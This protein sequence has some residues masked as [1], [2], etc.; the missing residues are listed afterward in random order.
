MLTEC[1]KDIPEL[2]G[3]YH[4]R[5]KEEILY[6]GKAKNLK[7][8]IR[9]YFTAKNTKKEEL[10]LEQSSSVD[11]TVTE[12]EIE[13]LILEEN[14]IKENQPRYNISLKDDKRYP[15]IKVTL[16]D[17]YPIVF[18]TRKLETDGS[19]YFGPFTNVQAVR[20]SLKTIKKIFPI[21]TCR[22]KKLPDKVCL[23]YHIGNCIAPCIGKVSKEEYRGLVEEVVDF[24]RGRS[25]KIEKIIEEKMWSA[26]EKLDFEK[27]AIYRNQLMSLRDL[28]KKQ[29]MVL[30]DNVSR[31]VIG[32]DVENENACAVVFQIREGK[33]IGKEHYFLHSIEESSIKDYLY[34]FLSGRYSNVSFIPEEIVLSGDIEN[35]ELFEKWFKSR[36]RIAK[37]G[38]LRRLIY[39]AEKNASLELKRELSVFPK[40]PAISLFALQEALALEEVPIRIEGFDISNISG[41]DSVGSCVVFVNGIPAKKEYRKFR[42]KGIKG[43]NDPAMIGEII[44]RRIKRLLDEENLPDLV[45]ID[46]GKSQL[47]AALAAIKKLTELRI[48]VIA[49]AK[50]FEEIHLPTGGI[51]SLSKRSPA[52][53][54]LMRIRDEAHRFA[55]N[56]HK[57]LRK[58]RL[59][60]SELDIIEN[61]GYK[62]KIALIQ[63]FGSK[64]RLQAASK[65]EIQKVKG[66]GKKLAE[67]IYTALH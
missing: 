39:M 6:I 20:R 47:S 45:L 37:R 49:L 50:R 27:A 31:D 64:K 44:Y 16:Q 62:R 25:E 34:R 63:H 53:K 33:M 15:Y 23:D 61:I 67:K 55:L 13:A 24:L 58:K 40:R 10:I 9:S 4:F 26:S 17:D 32:I 46:G 54:L 7:K 41:A 52:L 18:Y 51:I 5:S 60:L 57:G 14:E 8:R 3:V 59:S 42:I 19:I 29:R 30:K 65:E 12:S 66:I 22:G 21:R 1:P 11:Y 56:Y 43:I 38:D 35:R 48:P 28:S 36:I 2:P